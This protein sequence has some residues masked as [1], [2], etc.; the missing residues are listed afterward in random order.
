MRL[1]HGNE[2]RN[3]GLK[4]ERGIVVGEFDSGFCTWDKRRASFTHTHLKSVTTS[5]TGAFSL[6]CRR[7]NSLEIPNE[8]ING[9]F[10]RH[11]CGSSKS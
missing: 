8:E 7:G 5:Y 10:L 11:R 3:I 6:M 4:M 9:R 1:S 2:S